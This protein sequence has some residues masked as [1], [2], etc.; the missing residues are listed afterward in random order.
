MGRPRVIRIAEGITVEKH[1][2]RYVEEELRRHKAR[3]RAIESRKA[4]IARERPADF[5]PGGGRP[6]GT[7]GNPTQSAVIRMLQDEELQRW[8]HKAGV[9]EAGLALLPTNERRVIDMLLLTRR[10][11]VAGVALELGCSDRWVRQLKNEALYTLA[12]AM[13]II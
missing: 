2:L 6:E 10:Y 7:P 1:V 9:I 12:T 8:E 11:Q 5:A 3:L 4:A 13:G